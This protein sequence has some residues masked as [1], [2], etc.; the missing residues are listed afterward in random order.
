MLGNPPWLAENVGA[1]SASELV[2]AEAADEL[3]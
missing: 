3:A 2:D 1:V